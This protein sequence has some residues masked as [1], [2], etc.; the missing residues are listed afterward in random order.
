M[1]ARDIA[2]LVKAARAVV[3]AHDNRTGLDD[4]PDRIEELRALIPPEHVP[5]YWM[6]ETSGQ[7]RGPVMRYLENKPMT[8]ADIAA[9]RAYL[10]QWIMAPMWEGPGID[11]LRANV[12]TIADRKSLR[13]WLETAI[14]HG[15][16]PL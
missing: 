1:N 15:I 13:A 14:D 8:P 5:G 10:R 6:L 12:A 2:A 3:Q 4:L 9:M 16:D 7:L 11:E